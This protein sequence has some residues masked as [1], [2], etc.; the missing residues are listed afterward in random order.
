MDVSEAT[1]ARALF[2][3]S[4]QTLFRRTDRWFACLMACQ[5]LAGI[6]AAYWI[7]PRTWAG[8]TSRTHPHVWAAIFLGGAIS[9]FPIT[10][11]I[12][13]PGRKSTRYVI[14]V[15]QMLTSALLIHLNG[16]RIETHFHVFGSLAFLAVYRDW[17]VLVPATVVIAVDHLLRGLL[18]PQ[19]VYG[20]LSAS[21]WRSFEHAGWVIFEDIFLIASCVRGVEDMRCAAERQAELEAAHALVVS[22]KESAEA[23]NVAKGAF[24]A[25]ISH[26]IRTPMNGIFGM[27]ELAMETTDAV[28]RRDFLQRA[29]ACA[30][31]LMALLNDVL[32]FSKMEA[33]KCELEQIAFDVRDVLHGVLDTMAVEADRRGLELIG[34]VAPEIPADLRGDPGRLRQ[35]LMNLASNSLKFTERGEIEIRIEPVRELLATGAGSVMLRCTVRDT[36]IGIAPEKQRAIFD[37]FTQADSSDT[38]R[39]GGTGLGLAI[40]QHLVSL[41]GGEIGVESEVGEGSTFWFTIRLDG[42]AATP[43]ASRRLQGVRVLVVDDSVTSRHAVAGMLASAGCAVECAA[44]P[45]GLEAW[46]AAQD[47]RFDVLVLDLAMPE[48]GTV[49]W[50]RGVPIVG[51]RSIRADGSAAVPGRDVVAI[52]RKP[53]K[54]D[55][56]IDAVVSVV[57]RPRP[58]GSAS[59]SPPIANVAV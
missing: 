57:R 18:W 27:T 45:A 17:T 19:S 5:W 26:E 7:S 8:M 38:R 14:A 59:A 25:T 40:S 41:M 50:A 36:G 48:V 4:Q 12:V 32:D 3:E 13:R 30:Q 15:G 49:A 21:G 33:G 47:A 9:L 6:A 31:S 11:A 29:Q 52:V 35:I 46:L 2:E 28:E 10:L 37:A 34:T 39:Y 44:D 22:A 43:R 58:T 42:T 24:L 56:L 20:V 53:V 23:A 51:L 16:G 55:E 1:R 54:E